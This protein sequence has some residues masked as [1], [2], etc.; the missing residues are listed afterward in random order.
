MVYIIIYVD[1]CLIVGKP[2]ALDEIVLQLKE[3]LVIKCIGKIKDYIGCNVEETS[4]GYKYNQPKLI[5]RMVNKYA[6]ELSSIKY[7]GNT[8]VKSNE[9]IYV[10][11]NDT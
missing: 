8:P 9:K 6:N 1:D 11:A 4:Y 2:A 5:Q 10:A 7:H 3:H